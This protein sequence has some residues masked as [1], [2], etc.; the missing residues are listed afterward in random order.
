[1]YDNQEGVT[2]LILCSGQIYYDLVAEREKVSKPYTLLRVPAKQRE[3]RAWYQVPDMLE[4]SRLRLIIL[5]DGY[6]S[7]AATVVPY[8]RAASQLPAISATICARLSVR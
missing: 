1:M 2:R 4:P 5:S 7:P 8:A 6:A 3:T